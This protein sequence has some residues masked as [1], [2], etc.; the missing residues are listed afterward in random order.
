[1]KLLGDVGKKKFTKVFFLDL[2]LLQE[3]EKE[4]RLALQ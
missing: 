1:V 4:K 3:A 2:D